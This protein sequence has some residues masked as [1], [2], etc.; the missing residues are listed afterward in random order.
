MIMCIR[1]LVTT[2]VDYVD[3]AMLIK[4]RC[5][6]CN[7]P[8][9]TACT[10]CLCACFCSPDDDGGICAKRNSIVRSEHDKLCKQ[11][12]L[13]NVLVEDECVQLLD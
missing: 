10:K 2:A 3:V 5:F 12:N 1:L 11:I 7:K 9:A 6:A 4:K 8:C 13:P